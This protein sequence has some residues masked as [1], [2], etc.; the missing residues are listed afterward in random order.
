MVGVDLSAAMAPGV[1]V[2]RNRG[3]VVFVGGGRRPL[4]RLY[5]HANWRRGQP[6]P[7]WLPCP[8]M[9]FDSIELFPCTVDDLNNAVALKRME[10]C[11][12]P[13]MGTVRKA[14]AYG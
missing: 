5:A 1:Y 4:D 13:A 3:R 10:L 11:W 6:I 14:L 2:L 12:T 7:S 8:P 9:T